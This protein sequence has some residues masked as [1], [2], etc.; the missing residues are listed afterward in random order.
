MIKIVEKIAIAADLLKLTR[1]V[2]LFSYGFIL[3][4]VVRWYM[5]LQS[6]TIEQ[7]AFASTVVGAAIGV[8]AFYSK[9][10][11]TDYV[12]LSKTQ[13]SER[14]ERHNNHSDNSD[15]LNETVEIIR[16]INYN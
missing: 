1:R 9:A 5:I 14:P 4:Q 12:E 7:T 11:P 10:S 8:F 2:V 6:P 3:Y 15:F 16:P 13:S